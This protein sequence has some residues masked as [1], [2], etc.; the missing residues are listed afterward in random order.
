MARPR[1]DPDHL[2]RRSMAATREIAA[3]VREI[4]EL[5]AVPWDERDERWQ[6]RRVVVEARKGVLV[7]ECQDIA[8]MR[9]RQHDVPP[10]DAH[11]RAGP[12]SAT[13]VGR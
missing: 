9:A 8:A 2:R 4:G 1:T 5:L 13:E 6:A 7:A 12:P 10:P 11:Y 3:V